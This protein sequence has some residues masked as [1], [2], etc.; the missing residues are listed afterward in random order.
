MLAGSWEL[1]RVLMSAV[2]EQEVGDLE[3]SID[4]ATQ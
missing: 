3:V 1:Q 4:P 2:R